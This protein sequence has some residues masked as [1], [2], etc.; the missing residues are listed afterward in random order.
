VLGEQ[1]I[2]VWDGHCYARAVPGRLSL[3]G[4]GGVVRIGA[5]HDSTV[6][7]IQRLGATLRGVQTDR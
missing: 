4:K 6:D 2:F 5:V 3:E 7:V 1:G